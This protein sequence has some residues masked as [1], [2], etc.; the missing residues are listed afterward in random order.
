MRTFIR[1]ADAAGLREERYATPFG[2][3]ELLLDGDLPL[4]H[5]LPDPHRAAGGA[6]S[7]D[8]WCELLRA[9][10]SGEC[11]EFLF[12][13]AAWAKRTGCTP[14]EAAVVGAL[15]RVPY[16]HVVSYGQLAAA[17][18][19]PKAQR[20]TGSV[21]ARN[22]LTIILPCHRVV[23]GDGTLGRWSDEPA[24]KRRLLELEGVDVGGDGRL[25]GRR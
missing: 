16:G 11:V 10:F 12:D 4:G 8:S 5:E 25:R 13:G 14:F 2:V 15:A 17:A 18:G 1:S 20:A 22:P 21:M 19:Y 24:W 6:E 7:T 9:Y 23:R 3:G